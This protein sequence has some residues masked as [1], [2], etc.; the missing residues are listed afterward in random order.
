M[1][2]VVRTALLKSK[3]VPLP[4]H[5]IKGGAGGGDGGAGGGGETGGCGGGDSQSVRHVFL[6]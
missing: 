5:G 3:D 1:L 2:L 6:Q 4:M